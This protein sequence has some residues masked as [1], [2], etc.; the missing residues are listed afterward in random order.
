MK[1]ALAMKILVTY[2]T[3]CIRICTRTLYGTYE[4]HRRP[5]VVLTARWTFVFLVAH[6]LT[7]TAS[8]IS[9]TLARIPS[10]DPI[11]ET[12]TQVQQVLD[13]VK[14]LLIVLA[15]PFSYVVAALANCCCGVESNS[16]FDGMDKIYSEV[17]HHSIPIFFCVQN[18]FH[19]GDVN[20]FV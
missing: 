20:F 11:S 8:F 13:E 10:L 7:E 18:L 14:Y 12:T 1:P 4:D 3:E 6:N 9:A 2:V 16:D 15:V 19:N 5:L 17:S